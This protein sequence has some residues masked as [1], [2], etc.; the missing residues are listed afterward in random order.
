MKFLRP[1]N[2]GPFYAKEVRPATIVA[3]GAGP[4]ID[5]HARVVD[6]LGDPIPGLFAAGEATGGFLG[7]VYAGSGNNLAGC[8]VFGRIA[9]RNAAK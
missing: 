8:V 4:M 3:T 5:D 6:E 9:G 1:I 7:H 2:Q